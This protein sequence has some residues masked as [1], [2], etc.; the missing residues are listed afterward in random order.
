MNIAVLESSEFSA[1]SFALPFKF[2]TR[3]I[4]HK[5]MKR[6]VIWFVLLNFLNNS[7]I[8]R[9]FPYHKVHP[10]KMYNSVILVY[11]WLYNHHCNLILNIFIT[12]EINPITI[13]SLS[14]TTHLPQPHC[15]Y[16]ATC[17]HHTLP[18]GSH[19]LCLPHVFLPSLVNDSPRE[20]P[21][22]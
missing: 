8:K 7:F 6:E 1:F 19:P 17:A 4:F 16:Q 3:Q 14:F 22:E 11:L 13:N 9:L 21:Q 18:S 10:C 2:S 20:E 12:L 5:T 15:C